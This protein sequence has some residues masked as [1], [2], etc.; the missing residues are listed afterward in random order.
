MQGTNCCIEVYQGSLRAYESVES[1]F[2]IFRGSLRSSVRNTNGGSELLELDKCCY[3]PTC[4]SFHGHLSCSSCSAYGMYSN[5]REYC[6][7][8][9]DQCTCRLKAAAVAFPRCMRLKHPC[10]HTSAVARLVLCTPKGAVLL[11]RG[12]GEQPFSRATYLAKH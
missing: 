9:N 5:T 3:A 1:S 10:V 2:C 12:P 11:G 7:I 6:L 4:C 8:V